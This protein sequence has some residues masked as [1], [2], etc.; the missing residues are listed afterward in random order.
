MVELVVESALRRRSR[1]VALRVLLESSEIGVRKVGG[2][3]IFA[4]DIRVDAGCAV[5]VLQGGIL[6]C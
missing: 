1:S 6:E 3:L 2:K 5:A 4:S